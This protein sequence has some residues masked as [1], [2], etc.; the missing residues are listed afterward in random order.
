M[1]K[2]LLPLA[3]GS[4][5]SLVGCGSGDEAP[6]TETEVSVAASRVVFDPSN[7][8]VPAPSNILLS[9]SKDGT[10]NI[11]VDNP[12]DGANPQVALNGLDGWGTHSPITF[13]FSLPVDENGEEVTIEAAS[14]EAQ[15][16]IRVFK[17]TQGGP[18][19][20]ES[21]ISENPVVGAL[22]EAQEAAGETSTIA[23]SPGAVCS[24]DEELV[25]NE[26]FLVSATGNGSVAIIPTK[27]FTPETGYLVVLTD[28]IQDSLGR[29]VKASQT[30][31]LM[32]RSVAENPASDTT[33]ARNL[34]SLIN[35]YE[36]ALEQV[37]VDTEGVIYSS[38]FTTQSVGTALSAVKSLYAQRVPLGAVPALGLGPHPDGAATVG[39]LLDPEKYSPE[40]IQ[41]ASAANVYVGKVELP[42]YSPVPT[43]ENPTAPLTGRWTAKCD[44]AAAIL[45]AVANE[46]VNPA[47]AGIT[48]EMLANPE[49]LVR[50]DKGGCFNLTDSDN[51]PIDP[52]RHVTKYSPIP[53]KQADEEVTVFATT[54]NVA[55]ANM[56]RP[57]FGLE[58]DLSV[59]AEGWP[60][61]IFQHG[62]TADKSSAAA[63]AG[64]LAVAGYATI[65]IDHPLHGDRAFGAIDASSEAGAINYMNLQSLLT[66]RD[67]VRQ[68]IADLIGLRL[69]LSNASFHDAS[70]LNAQDV[71]FLGHSLGAIAGTGFTTI[72]NAPF[73]NSDLE[74]LAPMFKVQAS[75]LGM[76]GGSLANF[77]LASEEFGPVIKGNIAYDASEVFAEGVDAQATAAGIEKNTE[78]YLEL[79]AVA[80]EEFE[81]NGD[82][83]AFAEFQAS[84]NQF[85]FAAQTVV[86]SADPI[87][88]AKNLRALGT[89]LLAIEAVGDSVI[90]NNVPPL[91]GTEPLAALLGLTGISEMTT[92][93]G[94]PVRGIVRFGGDAEHRSLVD[95]GPSAAVTAEMQQQIALWFESDMMK[96]TIRDADLVE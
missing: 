77:L 61:V 54:P 30:Y 52:E 66:T 63:I 55:V 27:P 36:G 87:N 47:E 74:S 69:S 78:A 73:S 38:N 2:L 56:V 15:G 16:S 64:T 17:T 25:Q 37:G 58:A 11:P 57:N 68:S 95:A 80:Y 39:D 90:P 88:Y 5:L 35:T 4:A 94:D 3:I 24:I 12:D 28:N 21:C 18:A 1:K 10:L 8:E 93:D 46:E 29:S 19:N 48:A 26:D 67:N 72:A 71:H 84:L 51:N 92:N 9:E 60:V 85:A 49:L 44:S 79:L 65:A 86:D 20:A 32:K 89:P 83:E 43:A 45:N 41:V 81:T 7:G 70:T 23:S 75:A 31:T 59:P 50:E 76:P 14:L 6:V 96:V 13:E 82:P 53:E 40:A 62:I 91:G 22:H 33:S 42:Y 34:Q